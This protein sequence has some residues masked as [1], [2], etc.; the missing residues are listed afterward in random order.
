[1]KGQSTNVWKHLSL[2]HHPVHL[3]VNLNSATIFKVF[4]TIRFPIQVLA[5]NFSRNVSQF[6][7][8]SGF[9]FFLNDVLAY[10]LSLQ[11]SRMMWVNSASGTISSTSGWLKCHAFKTYIYIYIY[12]RT[13]IYGTDIYWMIGCQ[14]RV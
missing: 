5:R 4:F 11:I 3:N 10:K 8:P 7:I 12:A 9:S 6:L 2:L 1:M 14:L 13:H